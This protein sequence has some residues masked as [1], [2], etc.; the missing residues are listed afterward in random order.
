VGKILC[1]TR[2]GEG[3]QQTQDVAIAM[4]KDSGDPLLFLFVVDSSFLD[5]I[6]APVVVD[7]DVRLE[8]MGKFE[9]ARAKERGLSQ[10]VESETIVCHGKLRSELIA[11]A[12][13]NDVT[14]IV[15]GRPMGKEAIFAE[16][17]LKE[18][19]DAIHEETGI[20]VLCV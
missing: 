3:S 19:A 17:A 2:G 12:R 20:E 6:A 10:G 7:M 13:E 16:N 14:T 5:N 11:T 15:L 18:F 9:L 1:A 8:D 4:A